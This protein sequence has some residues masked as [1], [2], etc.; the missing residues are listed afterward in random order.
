MQ[1][2]RRSL[3]QSSACFFNVVTRAMLRSSRGVGERM[4]FQRWV[5]KVG[6]LL[7]NVTVATTSS[8]YYLLGM[9]LCSSNVLNEMTDKDRARAKPVFAEQATTNF[10]RE[11]PGS[12]QNS[13]VKCT[14]MFGH[15]PPRSLTTD[16]LQPLPSTED[17]PS[18]EA[19]MFV[20]CRNVSNLGLAA[21]R[22]R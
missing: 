19:L 13:K 8:F 21:E 1:G 5:C 10:D 9:N 7:H 4:R 14:Q 20:E 11:I 12:R 2:G 17:Y 3:G 6:K 18:Q 16:W 22:L 15:G